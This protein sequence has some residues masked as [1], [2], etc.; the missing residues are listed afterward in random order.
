MKKSIL[1]VIC[2]MLVLALLLSACSSFNQTPSTNVTETPLPECSRNFL[3]WTE[4]AEDGGFY[5]RMGNNNDPEH[6]L[7][8][9]TVSYKILSA[10]P[11]VLTGALSASEKG[12]EYTYDLPDGTSSGPWNDVH[13]TQEIYSTEIDVSISIEI[14]TSW[15]TITQEIL[16]TALPV[17]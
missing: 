3:I 7:L 10:D 4:N 2:S 14:T 15:C 6:S 16:L 1:L 13:F 12:Q 9:E 17:E 5:M 8:G 11:D